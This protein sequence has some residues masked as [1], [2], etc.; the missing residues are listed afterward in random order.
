M[1]PTTS[2][3]V[4]PSLCSRSGDNVYPDAQD[5][6]YETTY[7]DT[8]HRLYKPFG[9]VMLQQTMWCANG[10][11]E[12]YGDGAIWRNFLTPNNESWYSYDWGISTSWFSTQSSPTSP[13]RPNTSSLKRTS[14]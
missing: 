5:P 1:S 13:A 8:D 4:G 6:N 3:P 12:Y 14:A 10:N 2:R 9:A 11:K 7:F